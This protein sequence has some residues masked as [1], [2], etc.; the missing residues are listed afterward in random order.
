MGQAIGN[1]NQ[2]GEVVS[3][4]NPFCSLCGGLCEEVENEGAE[5]CC[6]CEGY[7]DPG[8]FPCEDRR[9]DDEAEDEDL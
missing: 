7:P 2:G 1:G 9:M 5:M 4:P 6:C 8:C 3:N